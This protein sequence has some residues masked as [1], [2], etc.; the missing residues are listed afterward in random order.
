VLLFA[1]T[2]TAP[3]LSGGVP[4]ATDTLTPWVPGGNGATGP[5]HNPVVADSALQFLPWQVFVRRSLAAG[6][7][8]LWDPNLFAGYPFLG[9]EENQLYYPVVW[10]L[11]LQPLAASFQVNIVFH[12]WLVGAG[13]YVLSR[14]LGAS[15]VGSLIA[16]LAFAGSGQL[17]TQLDLIGNTD[18]YGWLPWVVAAGELA[19]RRGSWVW[20]AV[21]GLLYGLLAVSG[22]LSWLIYSSVFLA[23]WF[24]ARIIV[25]G[26]AAYGFRG[27]DTSRM[28]RSVFHMQ[29]VRTV[30]LLAWGPALA[31]VHLLPV[32]ELAQLS[33]RVD[34]TVLPRSLSSL[35]TTLQALKNQLRIVVPL[36]YGTGAIG[37]PLSLNNALY[38]GLAPLAL[39]IIA[40]I[41]RRDR[42]V[43]FLGAVGL[44][45]LAVSL[46]LPGFNL[47]NQLPGIRAQVPER[48][49]Y[50]VIVCGALL[51]AFGFDTALS[52]ARRHPRT[53]AAVVIVLTALGAA[54]AMLLSGMHEQSRS[55]A[56]LYALQ[57]GAL[58][59]AGLMA[60]LLFLWGIALLILRGDYWRRGRGAL[61]ILLLGLTIADL[62]TY[63][64]NYNTFVP[65]AALQFDSPGARLMRS[66]PGIWRMQ[67]VDAGGA[68]F[69]PNTAT[70]YGLPD[71][72]GYDSLHLARYEAFWAAADPTVTGP[73]YAN[74]FNVIFRPQGYQAAQADLLNV[75]YIVAR[76]PLTGTAGL[77][78]PI[79]AQEMTIY[80]N[81]GALPRAFVVG[82]AEVMSAAAIP[83]RIAEPG[84]DPR[85]AVLLEQAPPPGVPATPSDGTAP[86]T[87]TITRYRNLSVDLTAQM[88]RPG[89]LVLGDVNYPGWQVTVDG[90]PAPL[91]TAYYILRAVPLPAGAHTVRFEFRPG[92]VLLGGALS[93]IALLAAL[94]VL[95]YSGFARFRSPRRQPV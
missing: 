4:V 6:E 10:L 83:A 25:A 19:W 87:A 34:A 1:L 65:A 9:S 32:V 22:H 80:R 86:G 24:G 44:G 82:G 93:G 27:C 15:R 85:R 56:A 20:T 91:Y 51:S 79:Y 12:V 52:L 70:L 13:M 92:S 43:W 8:P 67:A 68:L 73:G 54:L 74:Y 28:D 90:R 59:Q 35:V 78:A 42:R 46:K 53:M 26:A 40:L 58:Q 17:Y 71:V 88:D 62:L 76:A 23:L 45:A 2:L 55:D 48:I 39:A 64:P 75:Q 5:A 61:A 57:T 89:W 66:D 29:V 33:S 38:I 31:A 69:V 60:G 41:G 11:W 95:A 49:I 21:A 94:G 7:W 16:G 81:P 18:I 63:A 84:F 30:A 50:L 36:F 72:A 14:V 37:N 47:F 3:I 77:P